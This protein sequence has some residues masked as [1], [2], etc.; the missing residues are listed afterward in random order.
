MANVTLQ[1]VDHHYTDKDLADMA[2]FTYTLTDFNY[3][4]GTTS[5]LVYLSMVVISS[6]CVFTILYLDYILITGSTSTAWNSAIEL[7]ALALQSKQSNH[8]GQIPVGIDALSACNEGVGIRVN[9][10]DELELVF[11]N[12]RDIGSR[13]LRKI[14]R[15]KEY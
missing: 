15:N 8:L 13:D 7:V 6:Y 11:A 5:T 2:A 14:E 4:Y 10:E 1:R 9:A 12:D 3:D